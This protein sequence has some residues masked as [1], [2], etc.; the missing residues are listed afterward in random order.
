MHA[1][2][3]A[4]RAWAEERRRKAT[5]HP[6]AV[7]KPQ[8]PKRTPV[9]R[10]TPSSRRMQKMRDERDRFL[11]TCGCREGICSRGDIVGRQGGLDA[12]SYRYRA[13][14]AGAVCCV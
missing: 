10:A 2:I 3:E 8:G 11:Y 9:P 7:P 5:A 1:E 6:A 14:S 4:A 13:M 12:F